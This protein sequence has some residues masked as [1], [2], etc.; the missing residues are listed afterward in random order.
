MQEKK[1]K[2]QEKI[3]KKNNPTLILLTQCIQ[4][5]KRLHL[6]HTRAKIYLLFVFCLTGF[7]SL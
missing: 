3:K 7:K 1:R 5:S 4:Q 6:L 2:M